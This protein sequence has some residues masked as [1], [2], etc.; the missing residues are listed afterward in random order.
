M[1]LQDKMSRQFPGLELRKP[2]FY[3]WPVGI[4]FE[5]GVSDGTTSIHDQPAYLP[6]VYHRAIDLFEA[7]HAPE[8][9]LYIVVDVHEFNSSHAQ[10]RKLNVFAKYVKER[11]VLYRLRQDTLP[12]V[13]LENNEDGSYRKYRFSLHCC[14]SDL[15]YAALLRAICNQDMGRRPVVDVPV[16]IVN[17][18]KRTVFHVYDDR[19]CDVVAEEADTLRPVYERFSD[20]ILEYDRGAVDGMFG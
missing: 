15:R 20:W 17:V 7:L 3:S 13:Y 5:L 12:S 1:S 14:R 18:T 16:Y 10:R 9:D 4:R 8:D 6:G 11:S 19:G 2:L